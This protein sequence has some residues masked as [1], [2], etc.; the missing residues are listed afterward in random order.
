MCNIFLVENSEKQKSP[1]FLETNFLDASAH[2]YKRLCPSIHW[3]VGPWVHHVFLKCCGNGVLRTIKHQGPHRISFIQSFGHIVVRIELVS[4]RKNL[5]TFL[6][7]IFEYHLGQSKSHT[8]SKILSFLL[9]LV[10]TAAHWLSMISLG[11]SYPKY[12]FFMR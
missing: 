8:Q 9:K 2:L 5:E 11:P 7:E 12:N 1:R 10:S 4:L 3:S 6:L